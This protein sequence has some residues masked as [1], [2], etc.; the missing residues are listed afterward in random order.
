MRPII[1]AFALLLCF[2][3]SA[4][5]NSNFSSP[6]QQKVIK[7]FVEYNAYMAALN[8]PD[9]VA[10][11]AAM[12][13]FV[14]QFPNSVVKVEALEQ[15]MAAYQQ[16][17]NSAKVEETAN[18]I[19]GLDPDNVRALAISAYLKRSKATAGDAEAAK[20]AAANAERGIKALPSW[21][22]PDGMSDAA[23]LKLRDQMSAI[24][25]G[26]AGFAALQSKDYVHAR[27][28]YL[29]SVQ[30][31]PG[32]LQDVYQLSIADLEMKPIDVDGLWYIARAINLSKDNPTAQQSMTAYGKAKYKRYHGG[33]DGWDKLLAAAAATA[34]LPLDFSR[35]IKAAPTPAEIAVIAIRENDPGTLSFSDWEYVLSYRD[36]S[37][38]NKQAADRVW[39]TIQDKQKNGAAK[40]S[41]D[42]KVISATKDTVEAAVT[43]EN[44]QANKTDLHVV[45]EKPGADIPAAGSQ[46]KVIGVLT[47]YNPSPFMFVMEKAKLAK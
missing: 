37:P 46:I 8:T 13:A 31:D 5:S 45:L 42:V 24:F 34:A 18:R 35:T 17:N 16:S 14:K 26:T 41:I 15:A 28:Y 47:S 9:P 36:A 2:S 22:K 12:E 25:Y 1:I 10:K 32:N 4:L 21:T 3:S 20:E 33:E 38:E 11:A 44:Q 30:I 39:Q 27:E 7:D 29:K 6:L 19:L 23:F 40:L 43:D